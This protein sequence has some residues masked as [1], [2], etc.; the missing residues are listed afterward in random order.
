MFS[1]LLQR[2]KQLPTRCELAEY[3]GRGEQG[4][5]REVID[6]ADMRSTSTSVVL[7][8]CLYLAW[9]PVALSHRD[10]PTD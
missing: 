2:Y 6:G 5:N 9:M 8:G 10:G 4:K 1:V 7:V 3:P